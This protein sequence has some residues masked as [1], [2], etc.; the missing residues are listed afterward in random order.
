V[1]INSK[2][3]VSIRET[4]HTNRWF[5]GVTRLLANATL[6]GGAELKLI[7]EAGSFEFVFAA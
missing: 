3:V 7:G 1:G 6:S 4:G 2:I 5:G